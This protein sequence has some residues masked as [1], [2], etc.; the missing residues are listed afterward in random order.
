M[1]ID[2]DYLQ[3]AFS[4]N[5]LQVWKDIYHT[6]DLNSTEVF[7]VVETLKLLSFDHELYNK[8]R[9]EDFGS[10]EILS[11]YDGH[12]T[13]FTI[14]PSNHN[15]NYGNEHKLFQYIREK[16]PKKFNEE[17]GLSVSGDFLVDSLENFLKLRVEMTGP[18]YDWMWVKVYEAYLYQQRE[19]Y[20]FG[21]DVEAHV[22]EGWMSVVARYP[23]R[24]GLVSISTHIKDL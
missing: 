20:G 16:Y 13:M 17:M 9:D 3:K 15:R 12:H 11:P 21:I 2:K 6:D 23:L 5:E 18:K 1:N 19:K 10:R 7:T 22:T 4:E 8:L 14:T 24:G